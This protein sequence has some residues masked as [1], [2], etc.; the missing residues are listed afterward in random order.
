MPR[1]I[2]YEVSRPL[3]VGDT[4]PWAI[5]SELDQVSRPEN[6]FGGRLRVLLLLAIGA[7]AAVGG[8]AAAFAR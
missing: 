7:W 1:A 2:A 4:A 8:V 6:L 5:T 3:M